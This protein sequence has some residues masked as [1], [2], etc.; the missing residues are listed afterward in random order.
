MFQFQPGLFFS[1]YFPLLAHLKP[2]RHLYIT[3]RFVMQFYLS[4][5][6][7]GTTP[8]SGLDKELLRFSLCSDALLK[9]RKIKRSRSK[10]IL[11]QNVQ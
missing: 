7:K 1:L 2:T 8:A 5:C 4:R 11:T 6:V 10:R 9:Q 3:L